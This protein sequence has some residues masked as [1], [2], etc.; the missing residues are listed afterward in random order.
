MSARISLLNQTRDDWVDNTEPT[1]LTQQL[2][3][4]RDNAVRAQLLYEPHKDFSALLGVHHRDLSGSARLFRANIIKPGSND[5]VDG[6]DERKITID[7]KNESAL[8]NTGVNARLRW[9]L[10]PLSLHSITGYETLDTFNRGDI[11]GGFGNQF[12]PKSGP[13]FIPFSSETADGIPSHSQ[14]TQEFRLESNYAGPLNWQGGVFA[15]IEDY[16]VESFSYDSPAGSKQ[17]GYQRVKQT[18]DAYAIFGALSYDVTPAL[19]LRG[20]GRWTQDKKK[21]TVE[22]YEQSGF[23]PCVGPTLGIP[24]SGPLKCT[25]QQLAGLEPDGNLSASPKDSKFSWDVSGS[26][27]VNKDVNVYARVASGFRASSIQSAGAFNAKSVAGPETNT[28]YEAGVKADLFDRRARV[29]FSAFSY[30]VKDLQLTAVGGAG[31]A[32][33]LLNADKAKGQGF[34][35]DVQAYLTDRLLTSLG[36]GYNDT[37]I[38]DPGLAVSACAACTVTNPKNA[39]GKALIDGNSLPQAPK[40]TLNFTLKYSMPLAGGEAYAFTD[41]VYRSKVNFFLYESVEFA[42]K[43]LTEGGVRLGYT[44][45]GGKYDAAAFVRNLTDQVRVVGGID[46]NNLTGFINDPRTYGLQFRASF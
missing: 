4:Y 20:G 3:G 23:A 40:N 33:I 38:Q 41:W 34:E 22:A 39:E 31:N 19:R 13:G 15:F 17:D 42:S 12:T 18:N 26:Y 2:E 11:D 5:L 45:G 16:T 7:G 21:L 25:L 37:E 8:T 43:S 29:N 9:N 30:T 46:F 1:G 28:S 6:F 32:N 27:V 24:G 14:L 44:W 35:L 36:F 10:G